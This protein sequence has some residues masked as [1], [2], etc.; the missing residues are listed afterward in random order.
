[1]LHAESS[2]VDGRLCA[3]FEVATEN[4]IMSEPDIQE[5][6]KEKYGAAAKRVAEG[7]PA[8]CGAASL[9]GCDPIT[10]NLYGEVEKAS[11]PAEAVAAALGCGNPT[12]LA[13]LQAEGRGVDLRSGRRSCGVVVPVRMR[14]KRKSL[15]LG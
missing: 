1:M 9:S 14:R 7:K 8:C 13:K 2:G 11:L 15:W 6:V 5:V 10:R 3:N 4:E 12:A